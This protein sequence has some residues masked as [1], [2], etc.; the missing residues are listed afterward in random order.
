MQPVARLLL[1]LRS[2]QSVVKPKR[3]IELERIPAS[4]WPDSLSSLIRIHRLPGFLMYG[5][6]KGTFRAVP[7][8][9]PSVISNRIYT[10][11][12]YAAFPARYL[13]L[14]RRNVVSRFS[15]G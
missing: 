12:K 15:V 5:A 14:E 11:P 8:A 13:G 10:F 3:T 1:E 6:L 2:W 7:N 4:L 9:I